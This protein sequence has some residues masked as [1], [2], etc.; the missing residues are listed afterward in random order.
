MSLGFFRDVVIA[1]TNLLDEMVWDPHEPGWCWPI[2]D[3]R[4]YFE[5]GQDIRFKVG[6][7]VF[8]T[9]PTL[10]EQQEQAAA[11]EAVVGSA[12]RPFVPL[13]VK[14]MANDD[15]LGMLHWWG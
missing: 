4:L 7:V 1:P 8:Q 13:L 12:A 3:G 9:K 5:N 14:G 11:G 10:L 15:G 6:S 2:Q